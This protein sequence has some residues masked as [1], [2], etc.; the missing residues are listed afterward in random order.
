MKPLVT[1][2]NLCR[3]LFIFLA[4]SLSLSAAFAQ[5]YTG[6]FAREL[7]ADREN[8]DQVVFQPVPDMS[9][10]KLA[11]P[12]EPDSHVTFAFLYNGNTEKMEIPALLVEPQ[13]EDP[14]IWAD[15][16]LDKAFEEREKVKLRQSES[17]NPYL[18]EGI[19]N[20]TLKGGAF[21]SFP[22]FVQYFRSV[23]MEDMGEEDRLVLQSSEVFARGVV[24]IQGKKTLVAYGYNPRSKKIN[25]S[26]GKVGTDCDGDGAIDWDRFSP[27]AAEYSEEA[28]IFRVGNVYVSHRKADVEKNLIVLKTH[29]ATDYKRTEL[30]IGDVMP[31]FE[32]RDFQGQKR[33][34]SDFRGKYVLMDFWAIWCGPCRREMPYLKAAYQRYN[35]RGFEILGMNADE[36]DYISQVKGWLTKNDLSWTQATRESIL[37][38]M[39]S[40]RII[41]YPTTLLLD[42][43]GKVVSLNLTKKGQLDLRGKD[44]LES[45]KKVFSSGGY[46]P[47]AATRARS[48]KRESAAS[49]ESAATAQSPS[50]R[51]TL[52]SNNS[53][54]RVRVGNF[55]LPALPT[56]FT[57][58][59]VQ[60]ADV[61]CALPD[62][63]HYREEPR[64][65]AT[66][67]SISEEAADKNG[68]FDVGLSVSVTR[69]VQGDVSSLAQNTLEK[70]METSRVLSKSSNQTGEYETYNGF[71]KDG[72]RLIQHMVR[73]NTRTNSL[74]IISFECPEERWN[75]VNNKWGREILS[76]LIVIEKM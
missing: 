65:N 7:E 32:F 1:S 41:Y 21:P 4:T 10:Y 68:E 22:L 36:P 6:Q 48:E 64:G 28:V 42:P 69:K 58:K 55:E 74:V 73:V 66:F 49:S 38:V 14:Y 29:Q 76:H 17:D 25:L 9:R 37:P 51:P 71:V 8:L 11:R 2:Q 35:A 57:W 54:A 15:G 43:Q 50:S 5:E 62:G 20:E 39:R 3:W 70:L 53:G 19:V 56:G 23:K 63:W 18:W 44:L 12:V 40:L 31:D 34:L 26:N 47:Q 46:D 33:R 60:K 59:S 45:L 30:K 75:E 52:K 13:G 72:R 67:F 24:D 61:F 16:N 27:E